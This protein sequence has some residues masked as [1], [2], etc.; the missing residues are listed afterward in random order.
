M[1]HSMHQKSISYLKYLKNILFS[2]VLFLFILAIFGKGY[3]ALTSLGIVAFSCGVAIF[4]AMK[5]SKNM[6]FKKND[7]LLVSIIFSAQA[8]I[9]VIHFHNIINPDY[10]NIDELGVDLVGGTYYWDLAYFNY[11]ID[12]IAEYRIKNGY[13]SFDILQAAWKKNYFLAYFVSGLFYYGDAYA[14]N[15][16]VINIL[17]I[18][19]SGMVLALLANKI[20]GYLDINKR[21]MV[22][23]L[24]IL[25][26]LAWI[27]SHT[28][29]DIFGAFLVVLSVSLLYFSVS[30]IQKALF[31]ILSLGLVFQHR[32]AYFVSIAG[33]ILVRN[34][35]QAWKQKGSGVL[36]ILFLLLFFYYFI[37]SGAALTLIEV[38]QSS[39]E[40]SLLSGSN[41]VSLLEHALKMI[42]GPFPWTQYYD[43]SVVGYSAF[44]SSIFLLQAAW[45]LTV[46]YFL[47][48]KSKTIIIKKEFR[49]YLYIILLFGIPA[50]FSS[51]G[52]NIYL[53][54]SFMLS[55][56]FL[57]GISMTRFALTFVG[58][59]SAYVFLSAVYF[60]INI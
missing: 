9:G 50:V 45:H 31:S 5:T 54:P 59:V 37:L 14:L 56:V 3:G 35:T 55:L 30:K 28:M 48:L 27:P 16:M 23:Y 43:G 52:F 11:L 38:F 60:F 19:Y 12:Q 34:L 40:T 57:H 22:F 17:S 10:F 39:T 46:L 33:A 51:G 18:F 20:F 24:T 7:Y 6:I 26:P 32:S 42:V 15:F 8:L 4:Y 53:L 21:R 1:D 41:N 2:Y 13:F 58:S 29:R 44:Y 49:N 25:Q 36:I 47:L